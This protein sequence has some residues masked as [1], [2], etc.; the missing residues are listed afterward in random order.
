M[1]KYLYYNAPE[2]IKD[3]MLI[4]GMKMAKKYDHRQIVRFLDNCK[5]I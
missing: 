1:T 4:E 2:Q 3:K 5:K